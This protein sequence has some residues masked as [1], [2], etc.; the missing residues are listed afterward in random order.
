MTTTTQQHHEFKKSVASISDVRQRID[1]LNE[2]AWSLRYSDNRASLLF[3]D[4]ALIL[5]REEY[6]RKGIAEA[7]RTLAQSYL[8]ID[9]YIEALEYANEARDLFDEL[10]DFR[11]KA[12]VLN[13]LGGIYNQM[14][15]L[16]T[17]LKCNIQ[18]LHLRQEIEDQIGEVG[19]FN[20][21]GDTYMSM[22]DFEN[23]L[24]YFEHCL[25]LDYMSDGTNT[26]VKHNLAEVHFKLGKIDLAEDYI[27]QAIILGEKIKHRRILIASYNLR[28]LLYLE[29]GQDEKAIPWL[30]KAEELALEIEAKTELY[31]IYRNYSTFYDLQNNTAQAFHYFKKYNSLK[32]E[33]HSDEKMR[34]L[35]SMQFQYELRAIKADTEKERQKNQ[36][37]RRAYAKIEQQNLEI[38]LQHRNI[39]D[40][41]QYAQFIQ[42]AMLPSPRVI[43]TAMPD[44]FV[45]YLPKAVV[46]GDFYWVKDLG[47]KLLF[48]AVDCT[49]HGVPGAL[50]TTFAYDGLNRVVSEF[51][52]TQPAAML[53]KLNAVMVEE[54]AEAGDHLGAHKHSIRDG[55]DLS[56]CCLHRDTNIIEFAGAHNPLWICTENSNLLSGERIRGLEGENHTL[57]EVKADRQCVDFF[58]GLTL[59]PFTN[60]E[61]QLSKGDA[62]YVF[63]D[64][65]A[66]QFGGENGKKMLVK[67]FK[68]MLLSL[69]SETMVQ[70]KE[71]LLTRF[72]AWKRDQFQVDDVCIIGVRI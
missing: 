50:L 19:S 62:V 34:K 2:Y 59:A 46:S 43:D 69:T 60:H 35:K 61:I 47:D 67:R 58:S 27:E 64:G 36:Q 10:G 42:E 16:E 32:E 1:S 56:L 21:I 45:L 51:G 40:S 49:G 14:G 55:M 9:S 33:V 6:Y 38:S 53:D 24:Q 66:D 63:S 29:K 18:C 23:A 48:A 25:A 41:I 13:T 71:S 15:D 54:F 72:E 31:A 39:T 57:Y 52:I 26:V 7:L 20:N 68:E 37:L 3:A 17:R 30:K 22:G 70:Q 44:S 5:A 65:F 11:G 28:A 4:E 12:D 8:G